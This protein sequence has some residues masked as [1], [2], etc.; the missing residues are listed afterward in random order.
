MMPVSHVQSRVCHAT[1]LANAGSCPQSASRM[2][3]AVDLTATGV[4]VNK[5]FLNVTHC[6]FNRLKLNDSKS[7]YCFVLSLKMVSN[8][9]IKVVH[10]SGLRF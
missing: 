10:F 9:T 8:F 5:H 3:T 6:P 2:L 1:V 7:R 4:I